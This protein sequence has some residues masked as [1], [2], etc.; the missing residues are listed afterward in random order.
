[1]AASAVAH[2]REVVPDVQAERRSRGHEHVA[3]GRVRVVGVAGGAARR[4]R[5]HGAK[6]GARTVLREPQLAAKRRGADLEED[7]LLAR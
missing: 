6:V 2:E 3:V 4:T 7:R 5:R 1:M